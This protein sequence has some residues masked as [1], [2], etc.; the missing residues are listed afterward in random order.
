MNMHRWKEE[1]LSQS[2]TVVF[3]LMTY[4]GLPLIGKRVIDMVTSG[5]V[6]FRCIEALARRYPQM[7]AIPMSMDLSLEA[8]A[9]GSEVS[10]SENDVPTISRRIVHD[11][12]EMEALPV[13]RPD[14]ARIR[15]FIRAA[16]LTVDARLG[17]PVFTG[18]IGPF[19]LAG[20]L[21]DITEIMTGILMYPDEIHCLLRKTTQFIINYLNELIKT[22][23]NGVVMAEPAAGLLAE[24]ECNA[25][26]SS[27]IRQIV[28][29][30]Q[31]ETFLVVLHN[32]GHTETLVASMAGTGA[33]AFHFGNSV[34]MCA[35]LP[36][37]P[38]DR[39]AFGNLDPVNVI[40]NGT[41]ESIARAVRLLREKTR[42]FPHFILSSGCDIPPGTPLENIDALFQD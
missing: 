35:I 32:C 40:R 27:Y 9:F 2:Q 16:R 36:Q 4:P 1:I 17:K 15:E 25:F 30:V 21:V 23:V 24:E 38:P 22:G 12:T 3:P 11:H 10:F 19:S 6:Q 5:E 29:A 8:E 42:D 37:V 39:I 18:C 14:T 13:P 33:G 31:S 7:P 41:P 28:G 26:S 34:D 20:R